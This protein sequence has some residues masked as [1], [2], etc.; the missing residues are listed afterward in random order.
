MSVGKQSPS[1][2]DRSPMADGAPLAGVKSLAVVCPSWVGDA[3]MAT[4]VLRALRG[5]L[6]GGKIVGIMRP[7]LEE[8]LAGNPWLDEMVVC[9]N[10]GFVG[11]GKLGR[12]LRRVEAEAALILPN[13]FGTALGARLGGALVRI[14]YARGGRGW[15]LTHKK[16]VPLVGAFPRKP[17][18]M[19]K[20]YGELG[21]FA[22]GISAEKIGDRM[23]LVVTDRER[24]AADGLLKDVKGDFVLMN[25]G[26]NRSDK[27]WPAERFG[28]VAARLSDDMGV[29]IVVSGSPAER[30]ILEAVVRE[31]KA[32]GSRSAKLQ[33]AIVNIGERGVRLG[34]LKGVIER[35]RVLIT[36]DTGPR[37]IAAALGTPVVTLFGPTDHRWTTLNYQK[38]RILLAEPFLPEELVADRHVKACAIEKI[39][40]GDVVAAAEELMDRH[41]DEREAASSTLPS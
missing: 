39:S 3:V 7:G 40:V 24:R 28:K 13:S 25:P 12:A 1:V 32:A 15:L 14:G 27:R 23:E 19:V 11:P 35:A 30:D 9:D 4:P 20:Y 2:D 5:A 38:E 29:K 21:A 8:V 10:R 34:S 18:A 31:V 33:T 6:P 26:A 37:H 17:V 22:L 16:S 36:N 41:S